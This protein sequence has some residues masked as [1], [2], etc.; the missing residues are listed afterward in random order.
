MSSKTF[1]GSKMEVE[2]P[3]TEVFE[4][5]ERFA[6]HPVFR[7][8]NVTLNAEGKKLPYGEKNN[9]SIDQIRTNRGNTEGNTFSL[10]T[11][12][13]ENFY[14]IDFDTKKLYGCELKKFLDK[15]KNLFIE[16]RKGYHYY[17]F[18]NDMIEYTNQMK[19]YTDDA[20]DIDLIKTNNI[21]ETKSRKATG[22]FNN[23]NHYDWDELEKYFNVEKMNRDKK[24]KNVVTFTPPTSEDEPRAAGDSL[25]ERKVVVES[26]SKR[27]I[28]KLKIAVQHLDVKRAEDYKSWLDVGMA[29]Y[30]QG[31]NNNNQTLNIW[32][33]FSEK[34]DK[35]SGIG[36]LFSKWNS[37]KESKNPLTIKSIYHWLK[38]DNP[39][40][41]K[42]LCCPDNKYRE[43]YFGGIS[44]FMKHMNQ[45]VFYYATTGLYYYKIKENF[46]NMNKKHIARDYYE[47]FTFTVKDKENEKKTIKINPFDLWCSN[48]E[49]RDILK[50][51]M[52]P[53]EKTSDDVYNLWTGYDY[54]NT[55]DYDIEKIQYFL[56]HIKNIWA[57]GDEE[58]YEY[59]L[60]WISQIIQKPEKKTQTCVVLKSIEGV[61]KTI[62]LELLG[63]IMGDSYFDTVTKMTDALGRFNKSLE[64]K[65]LVNFNETNWG[66]DKKMA[67]TFKSLITD[68]TIKIEGKGVESYTTDNLINCIITTNEE[69]I[70][71]VSSKD[72]RFFLIECKDQKL[73]D[74]GIDKIL[75][76]PLQDLANFFYNRDISKFNSRNFKMTEMKQEQIVMNFDSVENFFYNILEGDVE[77][78]SLRTENGEFDPDEKLT[79]YKESLY[80]LYMEKTTGHHNRILCIVSFWK[81]VRKIFPEASFKKAQKTTKPKIQFESFN[82]LKKAIKKYSS[83][84][85]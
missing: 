23:I 16:T 24:L 55:K 76:T 40:E 42:K 29:L 1:L 65:I 8:I 56:D 46:V 25:V 61:G 26:L 77:I 38:T 27:D 36:G 59:L 64:R 53:H 22:N 47:K 80:E 52:K 70:V 43:W 54:K 18:I 63:K 41:F 13:I 51:V 12:H 75:K 11:K 66:G 15:Q 81:K 83:Q 37:F 7:H 48:I 79:I 17:V 5:L 84:E 57:N 21:W 3:V 28:E 82:S 45:E 6:G 73:N 68:N 31:N 67:G 74:E 44:E 62:I 78:F 35:Y 9:M 58:I 14:V 71:Q 19:I 33:T 69:W 10:F 60:N 49:R 72:R 4:E 85:K 2:T 34:S 32:N 39:E 20:F 30:N 50:I